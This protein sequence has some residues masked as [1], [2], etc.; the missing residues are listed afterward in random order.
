MATTEK[1]K[2]GGAIRETISVVIQA[3]LLAVII[4]SFI[5]QPFSIPSGSMKPTLLVG[6]YVFVSKWSYGFSRHSL[7][8]SPPI[9]SGRI[10]GSDPE[11]GDVVVFK[12][13]P[14][15]SKDYIKRVVGLPGDK[16]QLRDSV[17]LVNGQPIERLQNGMFE[18]DF[19]GRIIQTPIIQ[20]RMDNGA[21]YGTLDVQPGS[22]G[23]STPV[24]EVPEG[25]YFFLGD[26]RDNSA[27]SR[28]DVGL[29]PADH[30]VGKARFIFLSMEN[31]T[32]AWHIWK[33]PSD[34][35]WG[36]LFDGL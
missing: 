19:Q 32:P 5:V 22:S 6:D 11:R 14:D 30:L 24:F 4:R 3:I 34:M 17:V 36:R 9:F 16:V 1:A 7:P 10:F 20:E 21:M 31:G 25:K 15:P 2:E 26:N 18:G 8:F 13:P 33:W 28:Y 27:D 29:V 23:D 12:Y 35:R